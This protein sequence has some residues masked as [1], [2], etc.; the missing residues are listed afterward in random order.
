MSVTLTFDIHTC[1]SEGPNT[2]FREFG[3]N[4][5]QTKNYRLKMSNQNINRMQAAEIT[6][7]SDGMVTSAAA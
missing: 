2:S 6:P 7:G 3:A 4:H 5:T 1:P